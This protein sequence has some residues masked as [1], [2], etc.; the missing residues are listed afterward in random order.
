MKDAKRAISELHGQD[1]YAKNFGRKRRQNQRRERVAE[2]EVWVVAES[3][4][5]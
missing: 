4:D 3:D 5:R 1:F 2:E